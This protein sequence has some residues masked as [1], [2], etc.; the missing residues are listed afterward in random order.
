[1]IVT[2]LS[3]ASLPHSAIVHP[4]VLTYGYAHIFDRLSFPPNTGSANSAVGSG[5][6]GCA[7]LDYSHLPCFT[8]Y[9]YVVLE[10]PS[11]PVLKMCEGHTTH[12]YTLMLPSCVVVYSTYVCTYYVWH[13]Q[14][15]RVQLHIVAANLKHDLTMRF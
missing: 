1:M 12:T 7:H 3:P 8:I 13:I 14:T 11:N 2:C 15:Q 10:S 6:G 9:T 4:I 5:C